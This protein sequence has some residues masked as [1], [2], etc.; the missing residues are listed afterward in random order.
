VRSSRWGGGGHAGRR[1]LWVLVSAATAALIE[2]DGL[3]VLGEHRFKDLAAAER[4]YQLGERDFPAL[5]SLYRTN[6]PVPATPFLGRQEELIAV[7]SLMQQDIRLVTLVGPG[8]TGKTRLALQASAEASERFP[9][10]VWWVSLAPVRDPALVM[11]TVAQALEVTEESERA[12]VES[13]AGRLAGKQAL[14]LLDNAEHLLPEIADEIA[15][16]IDGASTASFLVTSRERLRLASEHAYAVPSLSERDGVALFAARARQV[17]AA[18]SET[19]AVIEL[20]HR[21][22]DLPLAIELAAART[23]VFSAEQLLERL[24]QRLDLLKGGRDADPRQQTLRATIEWSY[25]LLDEPERRLFRRLSVFV[26][27]CTFEA[28]EEV[29]EADPDSLQS[30]LDKSLLRRRE[31]LSGQNRYWMLETIRE[32]A[33]GQL[34]ESDDTPLPR[35]HATYFLGRAGA[36]THEFFGRQQP[37]CLARLRADYDNYRAAL[38]FFEEQGDAGALLTLASRLWRFWYVSSS[39]QEGGRWLDSALQHA[40]DR[41]LEYANAL[42]GRSVL[43]FLAGSLDEGDARQ[44]DA[45]LLFQELQHGWGVAEVLN[46]AGVVAVMR[47]D[48]ATADKFLEQSR[49]LAKDIAEPWLEGLATHNLADSALNA[50]DFERAA[51]L[52]TEALDLALASNNDDNVALSQGIRGHA[53]LLLG[54]IDAAEADLYKALARAQKLGRYEVV[55]WSLVTLAAASMRVG[56]VTRAAR[57]LGAVERWISDTG[58][59]PA[60]ASAALLRDTVTQIETVKSEDVAHARAEGTREGLDGAAACAL[61]QE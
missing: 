58:M 60:G 37:Q 34:D 32:Y 31:D 61:A 16:L 23:A 14:V 43:L 33:L 49:A 28:T 35:R 3:R 56:E 1:V 2:R 48:R 41:S 18:F 22:D 4:V 57:L 17:D 11:A 44:R 24:G 54:D 9:D 13:V 7:V 55:A 42:H 10:G 36:E 8:G 40:N 29:A 45:L 52:A 59:Q 47:S 27:G 6:L 19:P 25:E 30:L 21:L 39:L 46:D 12:L 38:T 20:C 26:G 5:K 50:G 51:R 53:Q 15:A